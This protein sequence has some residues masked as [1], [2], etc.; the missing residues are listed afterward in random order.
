MSSCSPCVALLHLLPCFLLWLLGLFLFLSPRILPVHPVL[1][2]HDSSHLE[3]VFKVS[4]I[5]SSLASLHLVSTVPYSRW[6][7]ALCDFFL[8][9]G[10]PSPSECFYTVQQ[11]RP[12]DC[13]VEVEEVLVSVGEAPT[14]SSNI[15]GFIFNLV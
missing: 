5:V 4:L 3:H 14:F 7:M 6:L 8:V 15:C 1:A 13:L 12:D 2:E 11:A 10:S 9:L